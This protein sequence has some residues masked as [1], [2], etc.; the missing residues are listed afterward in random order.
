[1]CENSSDFFDNYM[2][3]SLF[4]NIRP[5]KAFIVS[6]SATLEKHEYEKDY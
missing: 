1:M 5:K 6:M 3:L 2:F 4:G